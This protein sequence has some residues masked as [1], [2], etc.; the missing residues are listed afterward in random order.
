MYILEL[1]SVD[2]SVKSFKINLI[3]KKGKKILGVNDEKYN[4][5]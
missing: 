1:F 3:F 5:L 2:A 4:W